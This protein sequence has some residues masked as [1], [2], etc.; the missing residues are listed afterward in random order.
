[1]ARKYL[2]NQEAINAVAEFI[3]FNELG[4]AFHYLCGVL[5]DEEITISMIDYELLADLGKWLNEDE[6]VWLAV[7]P[8]W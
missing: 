8:P 1:L 4:V 3:D 2:R 7:R 5:E 6:R